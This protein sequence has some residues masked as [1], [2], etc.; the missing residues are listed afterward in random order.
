MQTR[1]ELPLNSEVAPN[2]PLKLSAAGFSN[3]A[4]RA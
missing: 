1:L 3:A 4:G 2:E